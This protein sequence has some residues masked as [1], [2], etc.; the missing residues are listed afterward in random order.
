KRCAHTL[1][2]NCAT[3]AV[4]AMLACSVEVFSV[5]QPPAVNPTII[6]NTAAPTQDHSQSVLLGLNA[7]QSAIALLNMSSSLIVARAT[8]SPRIQFSGV[9]MAGQ[10]GITLASDSSAFV[11][12]SGGKLLRAWP[13]IMSTG[14][15]PGRHIGRMAAC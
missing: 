2:A 6:V 3:A 14:C 13:H 12:A 7:F 5:T 4:L 1:A 10:E 9:P 8:P 11:T 15:G